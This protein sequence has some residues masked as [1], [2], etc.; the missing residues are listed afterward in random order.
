LLDFFGRESAE[1]KNWASNDVVHPD[2]RARVIAAFTA[3]MTTGVPYDIEQRCRRHDGVYCWFHA[4]AMPVR[5]AGG[6]MAGW[7]FLLTDI[8]D[9]KRAEEAT[10]ASEQN[11]DVIINTIPALAWSALP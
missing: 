2:D 3:T 5:D 10:R 7:C 8:D 6:T 9:R 1:L 11:L 4:R